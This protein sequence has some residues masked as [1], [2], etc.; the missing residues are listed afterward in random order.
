M[1][2]TSSRSE[3]SPANDGREILIRHD[4]SAGPVTAVKNLVVQTSLKHL[5]E[6]G[7]FERYKVLVDPVVLEQLNSGVAS[8]WTPVEIADGHY[9]ACDKMRLSDEELAKLGQATGERLQRTSLI[10]AKKKDQE[11]EV[12][13][14]SS[15]GQLH[16]IW[17]RH[18]QGG[19]VQ[20]VKLGAK[21]ML[22]EILG[23]GLNRHRHFRY[24]QL[25]V[26]ATTFEALGA[27]SPSAS[28]ASYDASG[29]EL[30]IRITW[31]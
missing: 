9:A 30:A 19:S 24:G 6:K 27:R 31:S 25:T 17:A 7:Y 12:D 21:D 1:A 15:V 14:W 4:L 20:V 18:Y 3:E 23:F 2:A 13:V 5:Q 10:S 29:D 16:R 8:E 22:L 26:M 28:I 11:P